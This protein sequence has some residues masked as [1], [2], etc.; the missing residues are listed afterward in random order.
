MLAPIFGMLPALYAAERGVSLAAIGM[1][2]MIARIADALIDPMVGHLSDQTRS[3]FGQRKPWIAAGALVC[4]ATVYPFFHPPEGAGAI[5][6][7]VTSSLLLFGW[8]M[9]GVPFSA[10]TTEIT[11]DYHE[12]ARL[13]AFRNLFGTAGA[14]VFLSSPYLLQKVTGTTAFNLNLLGYLAIGLAFLLPI[15]V[16]AALYAVPHGIMK[17][18]DKPSLRLLVDAVRTNRVLLLFI[19][20]TFLGGVNAGVTSGLQFLYLTSHMKLGAYVPLLGIAGVLATMVGIP[21]WLRV[22]GK[23]GKHRP[24][25]MARMAAA[26]LSPV[27]LLLYPGESSVGWLLGLSAIGGLLAAANSIAPQSILGDIIDYD[28]WKT[29]VNRSG[30]YF[31]FL[32]LLSKVT[33]ALG[34]GLALVLLGQI[35]YNVAGANTQTATL[36]LLALVGIVPLLLGLPEVWLILKFPLDARK[37][38]I[39]RRR[40]DQRERALAAAALLAEAARRS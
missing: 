25:A 39:I 36:G 26:L 30:N 20:I 18:T 37:H 16:G 19:A 6:F 15:S 34:T 21:L 3:R 38:G 22:M 40:I 27:V 9:L 2:M 35:G 11:G 13:F 31:A 23:L 17:A 24:W 1:V 33:T 32:M 29:G 8:T 14:F 5:Y 4:A 28:I 10:W 7:L 12:R